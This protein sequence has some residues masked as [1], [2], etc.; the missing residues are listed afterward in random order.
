MA[1]D[2][3]ARDEARITVI[4]LANMTA[5]IVDAMRDAEVPNHVVHTFLD[6]FDDLNSFALH[7]APAVV[8]G[9]IV[10][11]IRASVAHND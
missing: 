7:G 4:A 2:R 1:K 10:E 3:K 6:C 5:A 9:D 8:L 11:I